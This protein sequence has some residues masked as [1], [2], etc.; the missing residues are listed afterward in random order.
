[1]GQSLGLK[2]CYKMETKIDET[3]H[4]ASSCCPYAHKV[5]GK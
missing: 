1:M 4:A 5:S 2:I 3:F